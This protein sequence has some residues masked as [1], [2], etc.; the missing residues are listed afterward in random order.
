M[1]S[2]RDQ[3]TREGAEGFPRYCQRKGRDV[4]DLNTF[5]GLRMITRGVLTGSKQPLLCVHTGCLKRRVD[6]H[7]EFY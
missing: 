2:G 3:T 7:V 4:N 5:S 1:H 6:C